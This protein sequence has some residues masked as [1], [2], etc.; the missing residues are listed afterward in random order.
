[1]VDASECGKTDVTEAGCSAR[2][3]V[4]RCRQCEI[5]KE[6]NQLGAIGW[7]IP[8]KSR[9]RED[10]SA[11]PSTICGW[12]IPRKSRGRED[13]P[14]FPHALADGAYPENRGDERTL[15]KFITKDLDGAY[16]E[17]RGDERGQGSAPGRTDQPRGGSHSEWWCGGDPSAKM[18]RRSVPAGWD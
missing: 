6:G 13:K 14:P 17:N 3:S 16:P 9:G 18:R 10:P 12:R 4:F 8:R 2:S 15:R 11:A 5:R 7:R 1:M